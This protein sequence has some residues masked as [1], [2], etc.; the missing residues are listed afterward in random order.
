M[1]YILLFY[2]FFVFS[3]IFKKYIPLSLNFILDCFRLLPL[4]RRCTVDCPERVSSL[5]WGVIAST[6]KHSKFCNYLV[7]SRYAKA[8]SYCYQGV[9]HC[10]GSQKNMRIPVG[11][12]QPYSLSISDG[13]I[14]V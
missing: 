7:G 12:I 14:T 13:M 3:S 2:N 5:A 1:Q 8:N 9:V 11:S 10:R 6:A 4:Q